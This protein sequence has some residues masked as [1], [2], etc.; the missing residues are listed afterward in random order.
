[1]SGSRHSVVLV[2]EEREGEEE[3]RRR[4]R[5]DSAAGRSIRLETLLHRLCSSGV[6]QEE[7]C[8]VSG[9]VEGRQGG[10]L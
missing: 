8:H 10:G 9:E 3:K 5:D 4:R 1:M 7:A 6:G 2:E